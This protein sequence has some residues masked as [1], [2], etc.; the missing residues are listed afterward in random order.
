MNR[1]IRLALLGA[2]IFARNAHL[3]SLRALGQTFEIVAIYS[4]SGRSAQALADDPATGLSSAVAVYTDLSAL[5]ARPD[6]EAVDVVLPIHAVPG[7]VEA[8][9]Y[10][11][12]HVVS[13]KPIAP[14]LATARHLLDLF[15]RSQGRFP[16][17]QWMVA[18]NWRYEPAFVEASRLIREG[19]IGRPITFHWAFSLP[20]T[21]QSHYYHTP[22]RRDNSVPGGFV[23]DAGVHHMAAVRLVLGELVQVQAEAR[24]NRPDLPP[25]DTVAAVLT[26]ENGLIGTYAVTFAPDKHHSGGRAG[27]TPLTVVGSAG[28]LRVHRTL[29]EVE[30]DGQV[31][32]YPVQGMRGVEHELAA[33]A[34]AIRDGTPHANSP[35]AAA[36]DLAVVE[37]MLHSARAG[38][39]QIL[40]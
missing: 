19:A 23:L 35:H 20:M 6:V 36:Q 24:G 37:A 16:G 34:S 7:G 27:D 4:P 13:E 39:A 30:V 11:G 3:P 9:L 22:W 18:E 15:G 5:L 31:Q 33:F 12:K 28:Q 21:P 14:D 10:A 29:L 32:T 26:L 25:V 17:Q 38:Q 2:G 8:A 1:P 40:G